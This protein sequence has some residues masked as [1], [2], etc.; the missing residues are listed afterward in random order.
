MKLVLGFLLV[1]SSFNTFAACSVQT[2]G[3]CSSESTCK[4]L[5]PA[6]GPAVASWTSGTCVTIGATEKPV[7]D[8]TAVSGATGSK[9]PDAAAGAAAAG[10]A[11]S[12]H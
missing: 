3:E 8:C 10:S 7:P 6:S 1:V 4:A 9:G 5:N 11:G 12:N 2:P